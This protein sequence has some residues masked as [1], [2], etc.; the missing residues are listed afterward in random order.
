VCVS[1]VCLCVILFG[2][3]ES[4]V[5]RRSRSEGLRQGVLCECVVCVLVFYNLSNNSV[6]SPA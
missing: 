3:I 6:S 5:V 1:C 4:Q 2:A